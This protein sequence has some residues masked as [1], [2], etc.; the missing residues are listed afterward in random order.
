MPQKTRKGMFGIHQSD[1]KIVSRRCVSP[2]AAGA[3][4]TAFLLFLAG[5]FLAELAT[6]GGGV[7]T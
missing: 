7:C 5:F 6:G 4:A 1:G 3:K 2:Y